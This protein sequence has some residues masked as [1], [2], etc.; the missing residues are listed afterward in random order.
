M[1]GREKHSII[2]PQFALY[3]LNCGKNVFHFLRIFHSKNMKTNVYAVTTIFDF[4]LLPVTKKT[5]DVT[6]KM[7][8]ILNFTGFVSQHNKKQTADKC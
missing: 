7:Y 1:K 3:T 4:C 6:I 8:S 5:D 2:C